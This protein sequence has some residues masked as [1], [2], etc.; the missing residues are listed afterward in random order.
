MNIEND[1]DMDAK[2][3]RKRLTEE[4]KETI[5]RVFSTIKGRHPREVALG[6]LS[7]TR[8]YNSMANFYSRHCKKEGIAVLSPR[9]RYTEEEKD[10]VMRIFTEIDDCTERKAVIALLPC[11][12]GRSYSS[13][14][15]QFSIM[16]RTANKRKREEGES[17]SSSVEDD[18]RRRLM[19]EGYDSDG[20]DPLEDTTVIPEPTIDPTNTVAISP[21]TFA[22]RRLFDSDNAMAIPEP[23][24]HYEEG[25]PL[26]LLPDIEDIPTLTPSFMVGG[27][28]E[29]L[30]EYRGEMVF[31][32]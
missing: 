15:Q 23:V 30:P 13:L 28:D 17:G 4:E 32:Q 19:A 24:N 27:D 3:T 25:E 21:T 22:G 26:P 18:K 7:I 12:E 16:N 20:N 6:M 9:T 1:I 29:L 14:Y 5:I 31:T 8:N 11:F 2:I 10:A